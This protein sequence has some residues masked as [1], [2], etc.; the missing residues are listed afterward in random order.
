MRIS[1]LVLLC[2]V[3]TLAFTNTVR[4]QGWV[5][6]TGVSNTRGSSSLFATPAATDT[7]FIATELRGAAMKLHT[8]RQAPKE[9]EVVEEAAPKEKYVTTRDDY[10]AFLVDS[11]HV[12]EAVEDVVNEKEQLSQYRNNGMERTNA[13]EQDIE[14]M[15][16]EYGLKRP[17]VGDFGKT[18]A[19]ELRAIESIPEF[20]CH[21]YNFYFAHTAGGRMIG[22]QMSAMLLDKK[23][24]EFYKVRGFI[25]MSCVVLCCCNYGPFT[26]N[27]MFILRLTVGWRLERNQEFCQG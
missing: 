7:G 27:M 24:L 9:G 13:L 6:V 12:Y 22:K 10:L 2:A 11:K 26:D 8:T 17:E 19:A 16:K 20:M 25:V 18:Y 21:Y 1:I 5:G 23:T 4:Q 14:F 3:Q 15:V